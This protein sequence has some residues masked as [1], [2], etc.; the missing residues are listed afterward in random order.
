M[1]RFVLSLSDPVPLLL[2]AILHLDHLFLLV[3]NKTIHGLQECMMAYNRHRTLHPFVSSTSSLSNE[4]ARSREMLVYPSYHKSL[5]R[6][7]LR[8]S[9][10][11]PN[12]RSED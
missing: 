8:G 10:V 6:R 2:V 3:L 4:K 9:F 5:K 1:D 7:N 11:G 12:A